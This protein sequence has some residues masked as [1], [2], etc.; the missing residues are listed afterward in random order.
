M[1]T[2]SL[3]SGIMRIWAWPSGALSVAVIVRSFMERAF[4]EVGL[5]LL[6]S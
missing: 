3:G 4:G 5:D 1:L 6:R 2:I